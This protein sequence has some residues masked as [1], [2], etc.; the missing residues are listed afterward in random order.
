[1]MENGLHIQ[2]GDI[3]NVNEND[4]IN[5]RYVGNHFE[6]PITSRVIKPVAGI[7]GTGDL[8]GK[9]VV[10]DKLSDAVNTCPTDAGNTE[11]EM[12]MLADSN[13]SITIQSGQNIVLNTSGLDGNGTTLTSDNTTILNNGKLTFLAVEA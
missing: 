8:V 4:T 5:V 10:Y 13:E 6:G 7:A 11:T 12:I 3:I 9:Y 1:M 2:T